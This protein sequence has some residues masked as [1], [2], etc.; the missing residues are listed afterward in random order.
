MSQIFKKNFQISKLAILGDDTVCEI[1]LTVT[2]VIGK[3]TYW[4][5]RSIQRRFETFSIVTNTKNEFRVEL[6]APKKNEEYYLP[7]HVLANAV[8]MILYELHLRNPQHIPSFHLATYNRFLISEFTA[9][10]FKIDRNK[11]RTTMVYG[12]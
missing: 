5:V 12:E 7:K 2:N 10:G 6:P 4:E 8:Y 9:A 3:E 11:P 1:T